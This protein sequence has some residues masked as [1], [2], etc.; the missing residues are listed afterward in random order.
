MPGDTPS[1]SALA[2]GQLALAEGLGRLAE[3]IDASERRAKGTARTQA[4]AL[5]RL[6]ERIEAQTSR[7]EHRPDRGGTALGAALQAHDE[8]AQ[9]QVAALETRLSESVDA[10]HA[11]QA[12]AIAQ[13]HGEL[14]TLSA[15][16]AED[17]ARITEGLATLRLGLRAV[18]DRLADLAG[19]GPAPRY[20]SRPDSADASPGPAGAGGGHARSAAWR[21]APPQPAA[22]AAA[23]AAPGGTLAPE[24]GWSDETPASVLARGMDGPTGTPR[25]LAI[26]GAQPG[27]PTAFDGAPGGPWPP[28]APAP[29]RIQGM[30]RGPDPRHVVAIRSAGTDRDATPGRDH[31]GPTVAAGASGA[32]GVA[33]PDRLPS[34]PGGGED[35]GELRGAV[36]ALLSRLDWLEAGASAVAERAGPPAVWRRSAREPETGPQSTA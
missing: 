22:A 6:A 16:Q 13:I 4:E 14:R 7:L 25:S 8:R 3:I 29:A 19:A 11:A 9:D 2:E 26:P 18:N 36:Q 28:E 35:S 15:A 33:P 31:V 32:G 23:V 27:D 17:A 10:A 1:V 20:A 30:S 21:G 24:R 5:D 34:S 12:E